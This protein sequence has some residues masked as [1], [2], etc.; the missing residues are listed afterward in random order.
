M[1]DFGIVDA[2]LAALAA[3]LTIVTQS[4]EIINSALFKK[5]DF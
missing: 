3:I 5:H 1:I 2:I 4:R